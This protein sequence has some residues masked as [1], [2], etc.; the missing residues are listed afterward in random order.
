MYIYVY[1]YIYIYI[2]IIVAFCYGLYTSIKDMRSNNYDYSKKTRRKCLHCK[3]F[4][5]K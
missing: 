3:Q 1:I 2:Y 4:D 5:R